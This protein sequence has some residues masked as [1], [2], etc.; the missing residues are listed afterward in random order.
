M[1]FLD[2]LLACEVGSREAGKLQVASSSHGSPCNVG[3][4]DQN[5]KVCEEG[6]K[7]RSPHLLCISVG[8]AVTAHVLWCAD[9]SRS[10]DYCTDRL[11]WS[12][13]LKIKLKGPSQTA[14]IM[15]NWC[16]NEAMFLVD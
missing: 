3:M 8:A 9:Y 10:T 4:G 12:R 5:S 13:E 16:Q 11:R 2:S 7:V 15:R 1:A 14:I 6:C